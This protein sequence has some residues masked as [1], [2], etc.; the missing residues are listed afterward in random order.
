MKIR[1]N[2]KISPLTYQALCQKAKTVVQNF[3]CCLNQSPWDVMS[4]SPPS[5]PPSQPSP[6]FLPPL[7]KENEDHAKNESSLNVVPILDK[8]TKQPKYVKDKSIIR[9]YRTDGRS[10][11]CQR[12]AAKGYK[13]CEHHLP[14][15]RNNNINR[16]DEQG[17]SMDKPPKHPQSTRASTSSS[18][19]QNEFYYYSGFG[20]QWGKK[21]DEV[22]KNIGSDVPKIVEHKHELNP[23]LLS[24]LD[25]DANVADNKNKGKK[26]IESRRKRARKSIDRLNL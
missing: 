6:S 18:S 7:V 15:I 11:K 22:S 10:W 14:L 19:N 4:F 9:C 13:L 25:K 23:S 17:K 1:K 12:Q 26:N 21:R 8:A 16:A 3:D 2:F 5:T 24:R 20:P